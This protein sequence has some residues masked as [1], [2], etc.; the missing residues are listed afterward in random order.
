MILTVVGDVNE[1]KV[2]NLVDKLLSDC[3]VENQIANAKTYY[4]IEPTAVKTHRISKT[5][6]V[7]ITLAEI[8]FKENAYTLQE[9]FLRQFIYE[10][11]LD[12]IFGSTSKFYEEVYKKG[13]VTESIDTDVIWGVGY[14]ALL[15]SM[16]TNEPD[17]LYKMI[18]EEIKQQREHGLNREDFEL[19]KKS[20][21]SRFIKTTE[22]LDDFALLLFDITRVGYDLDFVFKFIENISFKDAEQLMHEGFKQERSVLSVVQANR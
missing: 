5:L 2:I 10:I 14:L 17:E 4:E 19:C 20:L 13:L 18:I 12:M 7:S 8:G 1:E 21:L 16:E 22:N 3:K 15:I 11:V 9:N 6:P